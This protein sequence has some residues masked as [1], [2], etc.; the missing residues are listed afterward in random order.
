MK[1][2][3][4]IETTVI[5]YLTSWR[6]EEVTVA[7][8]QEI[9]HQ[10]WQSASDRFELIGSQ[11]VVQE[12][13]AGDPK[14]ARERLE[15]LSKLLLVPTTEAGEQLA[16]ALILGNAVPESHPEDALHIAL[17]A[18]HGI[19]YLVT[20]NFRHIANAT[21]RTAIESIC[22]ESGFEPPVIC[23]PEELMETR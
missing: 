10:W 14:A 4:Y 1:S 23:T 8:H 6:R 19:Q 5:G 16:A 2:T 11:L 21:V 18:V 3:V 9:T 13:A 17:A 22:R 15:V 7:G 12:C 20:W